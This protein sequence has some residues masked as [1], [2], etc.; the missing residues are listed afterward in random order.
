[1]QF[2]SECLKT[3]LLISDGVTMMVTLLSG[4]SKENHFPWRVDFEVAVIDVVKTA[5]GEHVLS[6]LN[7]RDH[8]NLFPVSSYQMCSV[9]TQHSQAVLQNEKSSLM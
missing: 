6:S 5:Y 3:F 4:V 8:T 9:C 1:M 7:R 2:A